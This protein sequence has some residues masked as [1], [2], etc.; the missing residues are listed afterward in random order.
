[1]NSRLRL[2][3]ARIQ[4]IAG[5]L[6]PLWIEFLASSLFSNSNALF[7]PRCHENGNNSFR[8]SLLFVRLRHCWGALEAMLISI[9]PVHH[10]IKFLHNHRPSIWHNTAHYAI[11]RWI[12]WEYAA[13]YSKKIALSTPRCYR[14][15]TLRSSWEIEISR[16]FTDSKQHKY[17]NGKQMKWRK[18]LVCAR[19]Q[20]VNWVTVIIIKHKAHRRNFTRIE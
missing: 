19:Q 3:F 14:A 8:L 10:T 6:N 5:M 12:S 1:M 7:L 13:M 4:F 2:L 16:I 15:F 11:N 20:C 17:F 18:L 9:L